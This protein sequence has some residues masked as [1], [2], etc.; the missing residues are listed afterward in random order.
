M[1]IVTKELVDTALAE[2]RQTS[3]VAGDLLWDVQAPQP[4]R[5]CRRERRGKPCAEGGEHAA[6]SEKAEDEN[7][8]AG[9][10]MQ[11]VGQLT[12]RLWRSL[13]GEL[14]S[15]EGAPQPLSPLRRERSRECTREGELV[16]RWEREADVGGN[17]YVSV[18]RDLR[19]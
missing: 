2:T 7:G 10:S 11:Q 19:V 13:A 12:S 5:P 6:S 17:V 3:T 15:N 16:A 1:S 18:Q 14:P 8:I 9:V 4:P